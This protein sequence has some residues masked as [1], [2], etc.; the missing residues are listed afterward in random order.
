MILA[1]DFDDTIHDS[2][3][4]P[5]GGRMGP[6]MKGAKEAVDNFKRQGHTIIIH[7]VWG[8]K[9][10]APTIAKWLEYFQ[11]PYDEI[12]NIK[13]NADLFIDDKA[14]HFTDWANIHIQDMNQ[15]MNHAV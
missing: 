13:P 7:T 5:K 1:I 6:P 11:I 15:D 8:T 2:K 9:E 10:G 12:T 3:N 14:V 4:P